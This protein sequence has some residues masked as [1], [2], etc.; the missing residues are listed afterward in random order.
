MRQALVR[1]RHGARLAAL[2]IHALGCSRIQ[3]SL[4]SDPGALQ[5]VA[6]GFGLAQRPLQRHPRAVGAIFPFAS[7]LG[8][9]WRLHC[10]RRMPVGIRWSAFQEQYPHGMV[11]YTAHDGR[12]TQIW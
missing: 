12:P 7:T 11:R 6:R 10:D 8:T 4:A 9:V 1:R 5:T 2:S 3:V